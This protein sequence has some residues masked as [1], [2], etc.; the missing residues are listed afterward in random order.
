MKASLE[1]TSFQTSTGLAP[2]TPADGGSRSNGNNQ[3]STPNSNTQPS[4]NNSGKN[5]F[6]GKGRGKGNKRSSYDPPG[7]P[8]G[9]SKLCFFCRDFTTFEQANH[10]LKDCPHYRGVRKSWWEQHNAAT[11]NTSS[12]PTSPTTEGN[13]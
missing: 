8:V 5:H 9:W 2:K 3:N 10:P 13:H 1:A 7:K 12:S 6:K 4:S 11:S